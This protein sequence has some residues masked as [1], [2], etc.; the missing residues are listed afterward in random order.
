MSIDNNKNTTA[1]MA[2]YG[3]GR[4]LAEFMTGAYGLMV[5]YFFETELRVSGL[6]VSLATVIYSI[7]NAVNDPLIGYSTGKDRKIT[8]KYGKRFPWICIGLVLCIIAFIIIFA[9]PSVFLPVGKEQVNSKSPLIF[10]WMVVFVCLYDF[11]YSLWEVNYQAVFPDKFRGG[12]ERRKAATIGT[13]IGVFGIALGSVVPPLFYKY[14]Q[15]QTFLKS[16]I[17]ISAIAFVGSI[18]IRSG[19]RETPEMRQRYEEKLNKEKDEKGPGFVKCLINSVKYREFRAYVLL[20]FFYQSA[21]MCMTGSVNYVARGV[22]GFENGSA[23]TPIFAGMLIGALI[24]IFAW[25]AIGKKFKNNNQKLL[26]IT[27]I[28]MSVASASMIFANSKLGF[29]AGMFAWGIGFGGFWT[30]MNPAMAD[31]VDSV[32]VKENRRDDGILLG[33]KAF[34][35]RLSYASQAVVFWLCHKLTNYNPS[36]NGKQE[37]LARLGI[38]LH[39]S[40]VPALFFLVGGLV[41]A[42]VNTLTPKSVEDNKKRLKELNI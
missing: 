12:D 5:F 1:V 20:I 35:S 34:F 17:I 22:L 11:C 39:I 41:F 40:L 27:S 9:V 24:S 10:A 4:F 14:G 37:A 30:F 19:V 13:V 42:A 3:I 21:C 33:I 32:V 38:K 25:S 6:F 18:L 29:A 26:V 7:W 15:P 31:V 28:F 16:A 23:T 2:S 36:I 8:R